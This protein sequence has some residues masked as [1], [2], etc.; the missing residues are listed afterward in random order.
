MKRK[1][2]EYW[3]LV[4]PLYFG[5]HTASRELCLWDWECLLIR[6]IQIECSSDRECRYYSMCN[7]HL[8]RW[9]VQRVWASLAVISPHHTHFAWSAPLTR[10]CWIG[11]RS[12][13][14]G[15]KSVQANLFINLLLQDSLSNTTREQSW[16]ALFPNRR[17]FNF[18]KSIHYSHS[19]HSRFNFN[20]AL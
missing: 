2:R 4:C 1:R 18:G 15:W 17:D 10:K 11:T 6:S 7:C 20:D 19:T 3:T 13:Q 14:V 5:T 12:C 8:L 16:N 9:R